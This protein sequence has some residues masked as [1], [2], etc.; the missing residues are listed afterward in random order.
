MGRNREF[1]SA[2][3]IDNISSVAAVMENLTAFSDA[4]PGCLQVAAFFD[5][6][7]IGSRTKQGALSALLTDA[8]EKSL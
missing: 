5:H 3:R 8:L 7:E 2:L 4:E 1:L 6:E